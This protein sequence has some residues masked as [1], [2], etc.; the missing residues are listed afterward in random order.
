MK[1][2]AQFYH[3]HKNFL[4]DGEML[5]PAKLTCATKRVEFLKTSSYRRP[6]ESNACVQPALPCVFHSEWR[7]KDGRE[8]AVLVNWTREEQAYDIEFEGVRRRGK[9]P[10]LSWRLLNH[11]PGV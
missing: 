10:P 11:A 4:F 7:A 8:A 2:S 6:H 9:L 1:D 5:K 3:D